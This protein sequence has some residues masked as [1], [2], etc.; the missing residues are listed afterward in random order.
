MNENQIHAAQVE[1]VR[2]IFSLQDKFNSIVDPNWKRKGFPFYRAAYF[3]MVE[4]GEHLNMWKWWKKTS[5]GDRE[6]AVLELVDILHFV[7]SD[8]IV[9]AR[10]P[11]FLVGA[12]KRAAGRKTVDGEPNY[13]TVYEMIDDFITMTI[14]GC[15]Y[16]STVGIP[17][18]QFFDVCASIGVTLDELVQKYIGKN[19]LNVFRQDKGYKTDGYVKIWGKGPGNI[20]LEDNHYLVQFRDELGD[21]LT[22]DA[23][24]AKLE[25][26]YAEVLSTTHQQ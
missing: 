25:Q 17:A 20:D 5:P 4:F 18:K 14:V 3:E 1:K 2:E 7:V 6:Q 13:D 16:G 23:L 26:K 12:Y 11:E 24:Y 21:Q 9:R 10:T 22:F 15:T 19:V 8:V